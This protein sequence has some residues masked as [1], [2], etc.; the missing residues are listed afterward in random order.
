M[1]EERSAE[2]IAAENRKKAEMMAIG[3]QNAKNLAKLQERDPK[4]AAQY[5]RDLLK[6]QT[7]TG[8]QTEEIKPLDPTYLY[9]TNQSVEDFGNTSFQPLQTTRNDLAPPSNFQP[10]K[11]PSP[12][13]KWKKYCRENPRD[14]R[15][16]N[17]SGSGYSYCAENPEDKRCHDE[18]N[19]YKD[20]GFFA[21]EVKHIFSPETRSAVNQ[22]KKPVS[23][24]YEQ[25][26]DDSQMKVDKVIRTE[27]RCKDGR[28]VLGYLDTTTGQKDCSPCN[29]ETFSNPNIYKNYKT[30]KKV[31]FNG[32]VPLSKQNGVSHFGEVNMK[33]CQTGNEEQ[34]LERSNQ[35]KTLNKVINVNTKDSVG[36][37]KITSPTNTSGLPFS[38]YDNDPTNVY[39]I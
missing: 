27:C 22:V 19:P 35:S 2:Q 13:R 33:G 20:L 28:K 30:K 29:R 12:D 14:K 9:T 18:H 6:H 37:A 8:L 11:E 26:R 39:G 38:M 5:E 15:C 7:A 31:K 21:T 10:P 23:T 17:M 16:I 36:G 4:K 25:G 24:L 34:S 1:A 3:E 32:H